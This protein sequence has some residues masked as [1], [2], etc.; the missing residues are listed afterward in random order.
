MS[1]PVNYTQSEASRSPAKNSHADPYGDI[2]QLAQVSASR[3][4]FFADLVRVVVRT[5]AS[6]YGALHVRYGAEVVQDDAHTGPTDP[7]FWKNSVQGFLTESLTEARPRA[8]LLQSKSGDAKVAFLSATLFDPAGPSVGAIALVVPLGQDVDWTTRL[9]ALEGLCRFASACTARLGG[10]TSADHAGAPV[11]E[12]GM[13]RAVTCDSA[14]EFAFAITNELRNKLGCEQVALGWVT[15][16]HVRILSISGLDQ[17]NRRS[18]GVASLRS[19]MEEC[20]DSRQAIVH[21]RQRDWAEQTS[22]AEFALHRQWHSAARGDAVASIPLRLGDRIV[23]ILS[24][25]SRSERAFGP[26]QMEEIRSRTEPLMPGLALLMQARRSVPRHVWESSKSAI[27]GLVAPGRWGRK[28]G[29]FLLALGSLE[30][31]FGSMA[32]ELSV[33]CVV[34]PAHVRHIHAP[35]EGVLRDAHAVQGDRVRQ[36]QVLCEFDH[37]ELDQQ[38]TELTAQAQVLEHERD[39]AMAAGAP[40][41]AQLALA[42]QE[43]VRA[44]LEIVNSRIERALIRA[45]FDGVVVWGDLRKSVGAV[46]QLGDPLFQVAPRDRWT[47]E[48]EVP[49]HAVEHVAPGLSG[50]FVAIADPTQAMSLALSRLRSGAELRRGSNVYV[51]EAEM[52]TDSPWVKS[53]MEGVARIQVGERRILWVLTHRFVDY[54]RLNLWL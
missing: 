43:L 40:V 13:S 14:E 16:Q 11:A 45:P 28:V 34:A 9:A 49:Q 51:A 50:E 26:D 30:L 41:E 19:A 3:A 1:P 52:T 4:R 47:V 22:G 5:F 46:L 6:P 20:L 21:P 42:N 53:G 23:A 17:V 39:R 15:R 35:F 36:G 7:R 25:R 29:V 38:K 24:L 33:P 44:K 2:A 27:E 12:R 10:R 48:I 31:L 18:P 8:K 54:L 32:Y 37:R